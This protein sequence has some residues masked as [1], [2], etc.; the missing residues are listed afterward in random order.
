MPTYCYATTGTTAL[1]VI[2][3]ATD[4][5]ASTVTCA[6]NTVYCAAS[7]DG[8]WVAVSFNNG[9]IQFIPTSTLT[10]NAAITVGATFG[11]GTW[12]LVWHPDSS[13]VWVQ[14]STNVT[15]V[16]PAGTVDAPV[17]PTGTYGTSNQ[18]QICITPDG[19]KLYVSA[20]PRFYEID[21]ASRTSSR[22]WNV[23]DATYGL[24]TDGTTVWAAGN[25][26]IYVVPIATGTLGSASGPATNHR[27]LALPRDGSAVI[28]VAEP[29]QNEMFSLDHSLPSS[30]LHTVTGLPTCQSLAVLPGGAKIYVS[31]RANSRVRVVPTSTWT[32]S[33]PIT[34][35]GS[36]CWSVAI[37]GSPGTGPPP[38][39]TGTAA[40][41][42]GPV[43][44]QIGGGSLPPP[45][46]TSPTIAG[47][48]TLNLGPVVVIV[49][50]APAAAIAAGPIIIVAEGGRPGL[51]GGYP[52]PGYRGRWRLTLHQ[53][54]FTPKT[55]AQ[56]IIAE[57]ADARSRQLTQAWNTPATLTFALDGHSQPAGLI[58]E[59]EH[60]VVAWRWDDLTGIEQPVFRGPV[61][62]S[63]DQITEQSHVVTFTCHD[64]LAVLA[65]RLLTATYTVTA[66]DQDLI[67][68]DL[69]ALASSV[70]TS[71]G[72]SLSPQSFLPVNLFSANPNGTLRGLSGHTRDRTYYGSQNVGQA[73]D[74]LAKSVYGFDYD[75][76]PSA[77]D[78]H[79]SLRIFYPQQ[80]VTRTEGIALQ[81]G[82]TVAN[83]T[84]TVDSAAYANYVR[85]LGNNTSANPTPQFF[86]EA[87][88]STATSL[89]TPV[90]LWMAAADA[91]DATVQ[92]A[93]D[94]KAAGDLG[95]DAILVPSY[96]LGLAPGAYTWGNP[97]MGEVVPL[98]VNSGRL[99]VNTSVRVLGIAYTI[100]DDGQE[101]VTLTVARPRPTLAG[102][103]NKADRNIKAL[104]RR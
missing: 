21:T 7:P 10:P 83:L 103:F 75:V 61:T 39:P 18:T 55:L 35:G 96:T 66:R 47:A 5:V 36:T 44:T 94:D 40:L 6:A 14:G 3:T 81:Y 72:T 45:V 51:P 13:K 98:I 49:V 28:Y 15:S 27:D 60:D 102:L 56:T 37:A 85:V 91:P 73:I 77:V 104:A 4:T 69:L 86:S 2:D 64:Y 19:S 99:N 26:G 80:G 57:L 76:A 17:T 25:F 68:G 84:R 20:S 1:A 16:S 88:D 93:L 53:R 59:L 71:S 63:E 65:R 67:A 38:T 30:V 8:N 54:A 22:N 33:S 41:N 24:A 12:A 23:G 74:D 50:V 29:F 32:P 89:A 31:D 70:S 62:H 90:G 92:S 95:L 100:G 101:D 52:I 42:L 82:S 48:A 78:D 34:L 11:A 43:A 9:Q 97:K 58:S 79:D 87:W 46:I